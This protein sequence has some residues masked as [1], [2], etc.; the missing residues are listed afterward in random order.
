MEF[1]FGMSTSPE[2]QNINVVVRERHGLYANTYHIIHPKGQHEQVPHS[3][4]IAKFAI[5]TPLSEGPKTARN[6]PNIGLLPLVYISI[7]DIYKI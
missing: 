6:E 7:I 5:L 3:G 1:R 4:A 2:G